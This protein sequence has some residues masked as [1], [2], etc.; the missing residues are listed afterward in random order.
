MGAEG[1]ASGGPVE[2]ETGAGLLKVED[3]QGPGVLGSPGLPRPEVGAA[4]CTESSKKL[5][6]LVPWA[7][8]ETLTGQVGAMLR[9]PGLW[10]A[11]NRPRARVGMVELVRQGSCGGG[12]WS[13]LGGVIPLGWLGAVVWSADSSRT[14]WGAPRG[15]PD[16]RGPNG[17]KSF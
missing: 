10:Q 6:R 15:L 2:L 8:G 3:G 12:P 4:Q 17:K 14:F 13:S 5:G 9:A 1:G 7:H 16:S 11:A